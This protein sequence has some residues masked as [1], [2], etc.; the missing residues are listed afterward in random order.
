MAYTSQFTIYS[1]ADASHPVLNGTSGS[2]LALLNACLVTGYGSK[3]GAGWTKTGSI[4][5]ANGVSISDNNNCGIFVQP[6]GSQATLFLADNASSAGAGATRN[7]RATGFEYVTQFTSSVPAIITGSNQFPTYAQVSVGNGVVA[8]RKS[9]TADATER[10][11]IVFADSS[12]MYY[13]AV[14]GDSISGVYRGFA[15]GDIF[16][17][18]VGS[19]DISKCIIIGVP[20]ESQADWGNNDRLDRL[21]DVST[22]IPGHFMKRSFGGFGGSITCGKH[23][24]GAK[25]STTHL[26]GLT[27]YVNGADNGMY[28][29]PVWVHEDVNSCIRGRMRGFWHLCHPVASFSDGQVLTGTDDFAGKTFQV[30]GLGGNGGNFCIETSATVETN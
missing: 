2:L 8:V 30:V 18:V 21:D 22:A 7:A 16:S 28:I 23:G 1:S 27:Q 13:F 15:F 26:L 24:D 10:Q 17:L 5:S 20:L 29:S 6:T 11:W 3:P 19:N 9:L 14:T 12:S 4:D 25:G